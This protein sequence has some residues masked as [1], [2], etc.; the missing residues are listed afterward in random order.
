MVVW[1][2]DRLPLLQLDDKAHT[3]YTS[4]NKKTASAIPS[5]PPLGVCYQGVTGRI[6]YLEITILV[7]YIKIPSTINLKNIVQLI[8]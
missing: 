5:S 6:Q 4:F 2:S 3:L 8:F 1:P 7:R